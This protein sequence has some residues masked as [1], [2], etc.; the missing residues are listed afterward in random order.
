MCDKRWLLATMLAGVLAPPAAAQQATLHGQIRPRYEF[1]DPFF[2]GGRD[3]FTSMRVRAA[4]QAAL[5][6]GVDLF[7][8]LQ[9]VR[10]WGE[11]TNTLGDYRADN[12]DVH[13]AYIRYT[14]AELDWLTATLGRQETNFGGQRLVGAVD[15]TQQARSFDGVRFDLGSRSRVS[16]AAIAYKLADATAPAHDSDAELYGVY[17]T[18]DS[19]GTGDLE[20]YL[21][22]DRGLDADRTRQSTFGARYVFGGPVSGRFEGSLQRG[23]RAGS[24]VSAF[25][26][27]A[28]VGTSFAEGKADATL[29][30]DYLSGDDDPG[31][32]ETGVFSTLYATNHKFY[33]FADLF[34]DIPAHTGGRGLQDIAIKVTWRPVERL[35]LAA[36]V[37]TFRAADMTG[38]STAHFADEVDL[39]LTRALT[40]RLT[41]TS[42]L[43]VI[44]QDDALAEIGR[45]SEDMTW[46]YVM[47]NAVF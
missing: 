3:E 34:L 36:D 45:L 7:I 28:R 33:G 18:V 25:M 12:L 17:A 29:W 15:W 41:L 44:M 11:E 38:L 39:T 43:S 46:A 24:S 31:D 40:S 19:V 9:D 13:Q 42:G 27:G 8:Q 32:G 37:H 6:P 2:G 20:L 30:Y 23:D 1:R 26:V 21:L 16:A 22:H 35:T 4:V 5:D 47:L 10:T 14:P